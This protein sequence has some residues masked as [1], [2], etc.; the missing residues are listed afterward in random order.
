M[1]VLK[2]YLIHVLENLFLNS[3]LEFGRRMDNI[4]QNHVK[5]DQVS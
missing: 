4:R 1:T 2:L 5:L 3:F